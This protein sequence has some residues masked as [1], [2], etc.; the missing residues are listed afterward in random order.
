M[1]NELPARLAL[2]IP[3]VL[4]CTVKSPS[5]FSFCTR[6][7]LSERAQLCLPRGAQLE[8]VQAQAERQK[9][10]GVKQLGLRPFLRS[11]RILAKERRTDRTNKI[12]SV[13]AGAKPS[14]RA[15]CVPGDA[16]LHTEFPLHEV[17]PELLPQTLPSSQGG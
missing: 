5:S 8:N 7:A 15:L 2:G 1:E 13:H 6:T 10:D 16:P 12:R 11:H 4:Q 17:F 14:R 9:R 3:L